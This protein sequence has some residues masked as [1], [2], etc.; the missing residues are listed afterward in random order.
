MSNYESTFISSPEL[1]AEKLDEIVEKIKKIVETSGGKILVTQQLGRKRLSYPIK[2]FREGNYVYMELTG[3][4]EMVASIET[5]YKVNDTIIRYLT[6][7]AEKK[8]PVRVAAQVVKPEQAV[9]APEASAQPETS[10]KPAEQANPAEVKPV[11]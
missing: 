9:A 6:V 2:K 5:F 3:T 11:E 4:G 10:P 8:K 7:K 1:P